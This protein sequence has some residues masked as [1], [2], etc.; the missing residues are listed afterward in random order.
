[1]ILIVHIA[2]LAALSMLLA[3][4]AI[5][6]IRHLRI[7]NRLVLA[8]LALYPA[9]ALSAHWLGLAMPPWWHAPVLLAAAFALGL[10]IFK[11]GIMGGGDIKLLI[12]LTPW[13]GTALLAP[14]IIVVAL[15]GGV[16]AAAVLARQWLRPL[17]SRPDEGGTRA[18]MQ[19][20]VPY[21]VAIA[22]GGLY[23][24]GQLILNA[25]SR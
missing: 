14:F 19:A 9:H 20:P 1:M 13:A 7:S 21:G 4:I 8:V 24:A 2:I 11:T 25:L 5:G 6:D 18:V 3:V 15:G 10:V 17:A 12:V 22:A 23:V 16:V